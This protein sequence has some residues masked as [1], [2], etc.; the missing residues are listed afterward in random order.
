MF[1]QK[2]DLCFEREAWLTGKEVGV[3]CGESQ[4]QVRPQPMY[5][6]KEKK[7]RLMF[8]SQ[9]SKFMTIESLKLIMA[10]ETSNNPQIVSFSE[11]YY[12]LR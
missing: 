10:Y 5:K 11:I 9:R 1:I 12:K 7:K 2:Q 8:Q 3:G 4:V 6:K